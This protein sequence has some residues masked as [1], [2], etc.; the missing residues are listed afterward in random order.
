MMKLIPTIL[1]ILISLYSYS[2]SAE[3]KLGTQV[4]PPYQV[5]NGSEVSGIAVD[6]IDCIFNKMGMK[7]TITPLP[8]VRAQ[9]RTREGHLDGFF[10]A[11]KSAV[12]DNFAVLSKTFISQQWRIYFL[13]TSL[14]E[15]KLQNVK[16]FYRIGVR[17]N[18]NVAYWA[19]QEKF[20]VHESTS[21]PQKLISLLR[22][23]RIDG[24]M[25]N[26]NVFEYNIKQMKLKSSQFYSI[27][28][29]D[30]PLGVYFGITF[31]AKNPTF[32]DKFNR[33]VD[34]CQMKNSK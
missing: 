10:S 15:N 28:F 20:K 16:D 14:K 5:V 24:Y 1:F 33:A 4:W 26:S 29:M 25:E 9:N 34:K 18:S 6:S 7:H 2:T 17:I 31:L 32:M 12:R 23:D 8:W 21:D 11:S 13:K 19:K 3:V 22:R 27:P 30:N